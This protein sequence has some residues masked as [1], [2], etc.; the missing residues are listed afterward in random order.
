VRGKGKRER[1]KQNGKGEEV[2]VILSA[3][4]TYLLPSLACGTLFLEECLNS[5]KSLCE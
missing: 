3:I 1:Q 5:W 2:R 4:A